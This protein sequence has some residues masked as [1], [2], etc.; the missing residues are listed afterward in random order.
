MY[1]LK[2]SNL[3]DLGTFLDCSV[4]DVD[5]LIADPAI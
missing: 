4:T 3:L 1:G 2:Y 5:S